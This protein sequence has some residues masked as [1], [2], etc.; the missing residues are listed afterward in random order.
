MCNNEYESTGLPNNLRYGNA[1]VP[2][3]VLRNVYSPQEGLMYGTMFPE[4]V[5]PYYPNQSLTEVNYLK[6][7]NERGCR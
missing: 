5:Y 6:N 4:L 3:Q 1:Y 7:Y 2:V